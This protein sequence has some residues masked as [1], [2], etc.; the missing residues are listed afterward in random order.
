MHHRAY[1]L[2]VTAFG[3]AGTGLLLLAWPPVLLALLLGVDQASP[4]TTCC[5]RIAGAALL[6]IG[7]TCW[8]GRSDPLGPS[9]LGLITGVLI[10]DIAADG[11]LAYTG[12]CLGLVGIAL[13]PAV[14][15]H[16]ALAIWCVVCLRDRPCGKSSADKKEIEG[17]VGRSD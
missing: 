1:L 17:E 12:L 3:E 15:L 14:V 4:E 8:L 7:V 11:V 9:Q 5:A 16:A 13:W 2:I 6:A 10:Y